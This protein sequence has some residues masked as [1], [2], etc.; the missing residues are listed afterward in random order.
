MH[1]YFCLHW[2]VRFIE[3]RQANMAALN[4]LI[5]ALEQ[6]DA[7]QATD[8]DK[9]LKTVDQDRTQY[10]NLPNLFVCPTFAA[11]QLKQNELENPSAQDD[12]TNLPI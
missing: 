3:I 2:Q 4:S 7:Y 6:R 8:F 12:A 11:T 1:C 10:W 9:L 5:A